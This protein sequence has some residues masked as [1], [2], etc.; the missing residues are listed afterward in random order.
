[1]TLR[2]HKYTIYILTW[3]IRDSGGQVIEVNIESR[4]WS[5]NSQENTYENVCG[6]RKTKVQP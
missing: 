2:P 5:A 3:S 1:M 6:T 4:I